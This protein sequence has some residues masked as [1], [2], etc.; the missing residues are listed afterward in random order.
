MLEHILDLTSE[1]QRHLAAAPLQGA[2]AEEQQPAGRP[3]A[4]GLPILAQE[5]S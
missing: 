2:P 1:A 4:G 5:V 3:E